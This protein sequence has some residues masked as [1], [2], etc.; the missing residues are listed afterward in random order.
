MSQTLPQIYASSPLFGGNAAYVE[1]LYARWL[2]EP[3]T[4]PALWQ[5]F[6]AEQA[7]ADPRRATAAPALAS[8]PRAD[9]GRP[10]TE[11]QAAV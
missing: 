2:Q 9:P 3:A 10:A 7:P 5:Q 1:E 11:K 6:F 4:V 8:S